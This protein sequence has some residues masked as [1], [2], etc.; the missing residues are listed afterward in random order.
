MSATKVIFVGDQ[1]VGKTSI[2]HKYAGTTPDTRPTSAGVSYRASVPMEMGNVDLNVWDTP[3]SQTY[4]SLIPIY[5]RETKLAVLV[6]SVVDRVS[7]VNIQRWWD[8]LLSLYIPY[9]VLVGNKID[10][11]AIVLPQEGEQFAQSHFTHDSHDQECAVQFLQTSAVTGQGIDQL[12]HCLGE[13]VEYLK[14]GVPDRTD[15]GL[16]SDGREGVCTC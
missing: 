11:S 4:D 2:I 12:Y 7:F 14:F 13:V 3:G 9:V 6:Y 5:A 8:K 15:V 10:C 16:Y 1:L